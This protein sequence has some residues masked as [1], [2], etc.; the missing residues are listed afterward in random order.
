MATSCVRRKVAGAGFILIGLIV[1][2]AAAI[3]RIVAH[4]E[5]A[6]L[7]VPLGGMLTMGGLALSFTSGRRIAAR[8]FEEMEEVAR[9]P[10]RVRRRAESLPPAGHPEKAGAP[11]FG[12]LS[13][14]EPAVKVMPSRA[15]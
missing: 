14:A 13:E 11:G 12:L 10:R 5:A 2:V 3:G 6:F 1:W 7:G 15:A 9:A 4:P 8:Y